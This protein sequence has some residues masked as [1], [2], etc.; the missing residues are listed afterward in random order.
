[1]NK[2]VSPDGLSVPDAIL[3]AVARRA[4]GALTK[5]VWD[6]LDGTVSM[7]RIRRLLKQFESEGLVAR[8]RRVVWKRIILWVAT[9][10]GRAQAI[11]ARR[12]GTTGPA[13]ESAVPVG[14]APKEGR[15]NA[16]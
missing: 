4:S 9:D 2:G 11:E 1:M 10:R 6:A 8:D 15:D 3:W 13:R 7:G 5:N 14:D 16:G 12:A